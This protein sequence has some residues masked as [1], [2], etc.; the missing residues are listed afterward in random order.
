MITLKQIQRDWQERQEIK[1]T[2][3]EDNHN[4]F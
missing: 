2:L 1:W 4:F 3:S